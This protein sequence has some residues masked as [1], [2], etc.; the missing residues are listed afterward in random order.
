MSM[1][2]KDVLFYQNYLAA[3]E[4]AKKKGL[5]SQITQEKTDAK[6]ETMFQKC[7]SSKRKGYSS[8]VLCPMPNG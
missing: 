2:I 6:V 4:F 8:A 1:M 5:R 3:E 7:V